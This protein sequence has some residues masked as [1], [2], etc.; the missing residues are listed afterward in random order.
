MMNIKNVTWKVGTPETNG[1]YYILGGNV[2]GAQL[3]KF[4]DGKWEAKENEEIVAYGE[5]DSEKYRSVSLQ[6]QKSSDIKR[7]PAA[8]MRR[9]KLNTIGTVISLVGETK[10]ESEKKVIA[11]ALVLTDTA[12]A[13]YDWI[14]Q[15]SIEDETVMSRFDELVNFVETSLSAKSATVSKKPADT[16]K[17]KEPEPVPESVKD[18]PKPD[19]VA[20]TKPISEPV[21]QVEPEKPAELNIGWAEKEQIDVDD[22]PF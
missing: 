22:L 16:K 9:A 2:E 3:R 11:N 18:E 1:T 15:D 8:V 19:P 14:D 12:A 10:A 21:P 17:V 4:N 7:F 5:L 20:E 6:I 13:A